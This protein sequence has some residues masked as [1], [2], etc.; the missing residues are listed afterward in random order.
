MR[1]LAK[2][3]EWSTSFDTNDYS[4][5]R[6]ELVQR[7]DRA[8]L[9]SQTAVWLNRAMLDAGLAALGEGV[10]SGTAESFRALRVQ[11]AREEPALYPVAAEQVLRWNLYAFKWLSDSDLARY[12]RSR[13]RRARSGGWSP[14]RAPIA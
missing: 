2:F 7:I 14:A 3:Q 11:Y 8:L 13:S 9:T 5:E 6:I 4:V 12:A 10:P 1:T